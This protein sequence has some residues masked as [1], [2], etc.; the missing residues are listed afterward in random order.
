MSLNEAVDLR[1]SDHVGQ[2]VTEPLRVHEVEVT[3]CGCGIV[4][5][6]ACVCV[7][8]CACVGGHVCMCGCGCVSMGVWVIGEVYTLCV[9]T[10]VRLKNN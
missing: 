10:D 2:H 3:E 4:Q 5:H 1:Y 6:D 9:F 7:C 8:R